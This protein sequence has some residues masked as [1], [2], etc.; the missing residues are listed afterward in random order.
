MRTT[1]FLCGCEVEAQGGILGGGIMA[2][3]AHCQQLLI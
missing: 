3:C 2:H 1:C